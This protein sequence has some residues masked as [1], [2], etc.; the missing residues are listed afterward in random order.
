[1]P[2]LQCPFL[3]FHGLSIITT[4]K[5]KVLLQ[6]PLWHILWVSNHVDPKPTKSGRLPSPFK[7]QSLPTLPSPHPLLY[8]HPPATFPPPAIKHHP[9]LIL[10]FC[11]T[12]C[13]LEFFTSCSAWLHQ[14]RSAIL[15]GHPCNLFAPKGVDPPKSKVGI[16]KNLLLDRYK[17]HFQFQNP[18]NPPNALAL[19]T[20][21]TPNL[22]SKTLP[23]PCFATRKSF[24]KTTNSLGGSPEF[25]R[26]HLS[27]HLHCA[28]A[29]CS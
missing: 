14:E 4:K 22:A 28:V 17:F 6:S 13:R 1:M 3:D 10:E 23:F 8:P 19:S 9:C 7:L 24:N 11:N 25:H 29:S 15:Q 16:C 5:P 2:V 12:C 20:H 26:R 27:Q 21:S 18:Q